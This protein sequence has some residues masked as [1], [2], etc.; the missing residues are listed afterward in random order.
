MQEPLTV[1]KMMSFIQM[2][3]YHKPPTFELCTF[4]T[5]PVRSLLYTKGRIQQIL[6][7]VEICRTTVLYEIQN[8][9]WVTWTILRNS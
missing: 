8:L 9:K 3:L 1:H 6:S 5:R 4:S 7:S 2:E